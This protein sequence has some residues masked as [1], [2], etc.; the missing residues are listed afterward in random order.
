MKK[1]IVDDKRIDR[2]NTAIQISLFKVVD[3]WGNELNN[4]QYQDFIKAMFSGNPG[5]NMNKIEKRTR[6][7]RG[8]KR[9]A[10]L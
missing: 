2:I 10:S 7:M 4:E 9:G 5:V 1:I 3:H 8:M 6:I